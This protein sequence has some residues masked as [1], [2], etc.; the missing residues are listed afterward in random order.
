MEWIN[1]QP[2][3][4]SIKEAAIQKQPAPGLKTTEVKRIMGAPLRVT[5]IRSPVKGRA[6]EH[7]FYAEGT[8]LIFHNG[9]LTKTD[10]VEAK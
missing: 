7:W 1:S 3:S 6:E 10:H 5:K 9:L 2:W 4:T 8:V